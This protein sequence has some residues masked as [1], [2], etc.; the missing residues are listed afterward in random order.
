MYPM[1]FHKDLANVE[2]A[3]KTSN[4]YLSFALLP[5]SVVHESISTLRFCTVGVT[6]YKHQFCKGLQ[7]LCGETFGN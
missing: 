2:K 3:F 5:S 7:R 4:V 1:A 6:Q